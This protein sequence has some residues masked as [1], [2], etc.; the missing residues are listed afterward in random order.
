MALIQISNLPV[1]LPAET[2]DLVA[3]QTGAG[4]TGTY[5]LSDIANLRRALAEAHSSADYTMT[6]V[7][8]TPVPLN[9][10]DA[11]LISVGV[12]AT[13]T[14]TAGSNTA[15]FTVNAGKDGIYRVTMSIEV[16]SNTNESIDFILNINGV[17]TEFKTGV[18]LSDNAID[19][20]SAS[21]NTF[22]SLVATDV[23][24]IYINS[25]GATMSILID[26]L[27]FTLEKV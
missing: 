4:T 26:S 19:I 14:P 10:Y 27:T 3:Q 8:P 24:E 1:I 9:G 12:T 25:D 17:P 22:V 21:I 13:L 15:N 11:S 6:G 18:D 5:K 2:D 16:F 7:T 23:V 20:G